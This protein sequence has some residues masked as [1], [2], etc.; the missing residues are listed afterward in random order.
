MQAVR[1]RARPIGQGHGLDDA[2]GYREGDIMS[3]TGRLV[4]AGLIAALVAVPAAAIA[5]PIGEDQPAR[6]P[7]EC[8]PFTYVP[9]G[10]HSPAAWN[11]LLSLAACVQDSGHE[12][13]DDPDA[14]GEYVAR[15]GA[16]LAPVIALY[17]AA[18]QLGPEAVPVRAVYQLGMAHVGLLVRARSSIVAPPDPTSS[19]RAALHYRALHTALE[20]YLERTATI[21]LV[22]FLAVDQ[23]ATEN[24]WLAA[25]PVVSYM[26]RDARAQA[27]LLRASWPEIVLPSLALVAEP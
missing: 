10:R 18:V 20:P 9:G 26:V 2:A 6:I 15:L 24:P 3:R 25:D 5:E 23:V 8:R 11:Q 4:I 13:L 27:A 19:S 14:A 12:V 21:A 17:L 22:S 1:S 7:L 16:N